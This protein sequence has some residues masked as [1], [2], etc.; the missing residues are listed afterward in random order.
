[1]NEK[2]IYTDADITITNGEL[3]N[4]KPLEVLSRFIKLDELKDIK[5]KNLHNNI[6][7]KNRVINIPQ[8]EIN[9]SALNLLMSGTHN[10]DDTVDYH[11]TID[12]DEILSKKWISRKPQKTE[13]GVEEDDGGHRTRVFIN[14]KGYIDDDNITHYDRKGAKQA[15]K[16]D[17]HNEKQNLKSIL[18]DEFHWLRKD[19]D[20]KDDRKK[21]DGGG[22]FILQQDDPKPKDKKDKD[23]DLDDGDDYK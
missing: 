16:E 14:M 20:K 22:K 3:I 4:F 23:G 21:E 9:S 12:M 18:Q 11:F 15:L 19:K 10:F 17:L 6:E 1:V 2:K 5:F 8:M 13:F 7:I